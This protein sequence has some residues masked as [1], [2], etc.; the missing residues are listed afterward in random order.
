L[1]RAVTRARALAVVARPR[2]PC[3]R[4]SETTPNGRIYAS[5]GKLLKPGGG[6][7]EDHGSTTS[8]PSEPYATT[9]RVPVCLDGELRVRVGGWAEAVEVASAPRRCAPATTSDGDVRGGWHGV[10]VPGH[11]SSLCS[12]LQA[13]TRGGLG[14]GPR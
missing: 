5:D 12:L 10:T 11:R 9:I 8:P 3:A 7:A 1:L 14:G 4:D 2:L 6:K 13:A